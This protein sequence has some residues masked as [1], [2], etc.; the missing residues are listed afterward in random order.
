MDENEAPINIATFSSN[1]TLGFAEGAH[2]PTMPE[3]EHDHVPK[4]FKY[5][6]TMESEGFAGKMRTK[7]AFLNMNA[8]LHN[9]GNMTYDMFA[10]FTPDEIEKHIGVC[11]TPMVSLYHM[12]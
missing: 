12:T 2:A 5:N 9:A 3:E 6:F 1:A 8:S 4:K 7:A 10:K 11:I